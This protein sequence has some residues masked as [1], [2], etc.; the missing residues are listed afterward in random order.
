M[1]KGTGKMLKLVLKKNVKKRHLYRL[2]EGFNELVNR[3][4]WA[5]IL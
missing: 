5:N 1:N 4:R 2:P 3:C